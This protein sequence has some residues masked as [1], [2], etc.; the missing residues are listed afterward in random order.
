M[1][2]AL[3]TA[4]GATGMGA[5]LAWQPARTP[6]EQAFNAQR[7]TLDKVFNPAHPEQAI[8]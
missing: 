7:L 5:G 1:P 4:A 2:G 8:A 3:A 6:R